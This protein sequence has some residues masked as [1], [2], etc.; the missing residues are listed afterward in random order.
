MGNS[1]Y[2]ERLNLLRMI[3]LARRHVEEDKF[4]YALATLALAVDA[5]ALLIDSDSV[6]PKTYQAT[7][8]E[9]RK[10][11]DRRLGRAVNHSRC[12]IQY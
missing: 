1:I 11:P 8:W 10:P 6:T 7:L 4:E 3:A 2:E 12:S 5:C 9:W